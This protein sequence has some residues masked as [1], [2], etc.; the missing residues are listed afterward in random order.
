M[1]RP[2]SRLEYVDPWGV[3]KYLTVP[4]S[5]ASKGQL[6]LLD[7]L[8]VEYPED[9]TMAEANFLS[10]EALG[11]SVYAPLMASYPEEFASR[12]GTGCP[13]PLEALSVLWADGALRIAPAANAVPLSLL[14]V[15]KVI[16]KWT[17][18]RTKPRELWVLNALGA[19]KIGERMG[20]HLI[21]G[22]MARVIRDLT[23]TVLAGRKGIVT[24]PPD[25]A[26]MAKRITDDEVRAR[27]AF[28]KMK[29][30]DDNLVRIREAVLP[31]LEE[32]P[33]R[34]FAVSEVRSLAGLKSLKVA[35]SAL[36]H[37]ESMEV[38]ESALRSGSRGRERVWR[39]DIDKMRLWEP[40]YKELR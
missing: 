4:D 2:G 33:D 21:V 16:R 28:L 19:L 17:F 7:R 15:A 23:P 14:D 24:A 37:G 32:S 13:A 40:S 29:K 31:L 25:N 38:L 3:V 1:V 10:Y 26:Y 39:M 30:D 18:V 5:P 22:R 9:V 8:S 12:G 34:E 6:S 36:K 35:R 27:S 20:E 11:G